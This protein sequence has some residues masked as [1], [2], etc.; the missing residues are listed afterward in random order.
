MACEGQAVSTYE[1]AV[2]QEDG[3]VG[4]LGHERIVRHKDDRL[5]VSRREQAGDDG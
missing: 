3:P 4:E 5:A 1:L 2:L